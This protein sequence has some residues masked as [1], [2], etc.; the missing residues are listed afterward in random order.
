MTG[1]PEGM[2]DWPEFLPGSEDFLFISMLARGIEESEIYL[3]TLRDGRAADPVLLMKNATAARYTPA[4]GGRILFV[5]NDNLYAQTLNRTARKL[6][7][8]PEL[9]QQHVASSPAFG[10]AHFSVSRSGVVAW[11][12]GTAGLSQ[13]TIFNRQGKEIGTAGSPTVVQTLKLAPDENRL[14]IGFN[15]TAWLLEPGRPGQQ[16]LEQ[17]SRETLFSPDGLKFLDAIPRPGKASVLWST[18]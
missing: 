18:L 8:E 11:R 7:G 5:R 12:P 13:V 16:Q 14:L 4:G 6:E 9:V 2:S 1:R 15:A 10:R 3:A 17:G